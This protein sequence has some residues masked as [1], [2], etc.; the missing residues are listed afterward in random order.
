[1]WSSGITE[2]QAHNIEKV[3]KR[4]LR[5]I[6][7]PNILSYL[8]HLNFFRLESL[9]ER[10]KHLVLKFAKSLLTSDNHR[11]LLK[12]LTPINGRRVNSQSKQKTT[13]FRGK[14][15]WITFNTSF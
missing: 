12:L 4:A 6:A 1:M 9:N 15:V 2:I 13:H 3:Q 8:D 11:H 7:Y 5:I 14:F 10:R